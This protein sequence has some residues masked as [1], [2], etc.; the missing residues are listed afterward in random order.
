[1]ALL[2]PP[3]F[4]LLTLPPS[5]SKS[6]NSHQSVSLRF[7]WVL[8]E[9]FPQYLPAGCCIGVFQR[10]SLPNASFYRSVTAESQ[11][12]SISLRWMNVPFHRDSQSHSV[13][14]VLYQWL[15]TVLREPTHTHTPTLTHTHSQ[16][17]IWSALIKNNGQG[18]ET[19]LSVEVCCGSPSF[20][21]G[22]QSR[23]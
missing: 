1:M 5:S 19:K 21:R 10:V 14:L 23:R 8:F 2:S 4:F 11:S 16:E 6:D 22:N 17:D 9:E 15:S 12:P 3:P 7:H 18:F 20:S 13:K